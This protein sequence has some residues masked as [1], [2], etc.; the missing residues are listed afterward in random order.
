MRYRIAVLM[1]VMV[2][3]ASGL[4]AQTFGQYVTMMDS[5]AMEAPQIQTEFNRK[6][7]IRNLDYVSYPTGFQAPDGYIYVSYDL[8]RTRRG[9]IYLVKF[10][11]E[12]VLAGR[13]VSRDGY[14]KNLIFKPGKVH[15]SKA[16]VAAGKA[17]GNKK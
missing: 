14:L 5:L 12:D 3:T 9:E 17:A 15:K 7:R 10:R 6:Y 1:S 2:L 4:M 11:E 16:N 13:I 8:Q